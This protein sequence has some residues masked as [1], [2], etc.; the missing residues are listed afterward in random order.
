MKYFGSAVTD[1]GNSKK[2]NQDSMCLKIANTKNHGQVAMV[3][4]CDGM[5]GLDK[6]ELASATVIRAFVH[7]FEKELPAKLD[8]YSWQAL[9]AEWD[10]MI[11][12]QNY[13]ILE[14]SKKIYAEGVGTTISAMLIIEG[15]YMIA[16]VGDSRIYEISGDVRQLTEDQTYTQRE[17]KRGNMTVEEAKTHPQKNKLLQ[18]VGAS[19]TVV[20]DMLFGDIYPNTV[21]LLCSDGF[22]NQLTND[23][24]HECFNPTNAGSIEAMEQ[25]SK[26]LI[27]L[28]KGRKEKDNISAAVIK[29]IE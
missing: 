6:G 23:E 10:K 20:P 1:I 2:T 19:R 4:I 26:Y 7:W 9:S 3:I 25:N 27:D 5:G 15:K 17:I 8:T 12:A 22:R 21:Y 16:H 11:K 13:K 29:C 18:C 28:V 24:I 14:Y